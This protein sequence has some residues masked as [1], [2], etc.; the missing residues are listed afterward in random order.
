VQGTVERPTARG[1][2]RIPLSYRPRA[3]TNRGRDWLAQAE[4]DLEHA[5]TSRRAG[6]HDW[7]CFASHQ[8]AEKA[9]KGLHLHLGQDAWGHVVTRL[10]ADL[11]IEVPQG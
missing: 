5:E 3:V 11:P 6:Q 1:R 10:M 2:A 9:L 8:A 7:A 4:R